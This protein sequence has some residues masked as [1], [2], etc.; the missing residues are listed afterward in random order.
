[1][2]WRFFITAYTDKG[3]TFI[4]KPLSIKVEI[5]EPYIVSNNGEQENPK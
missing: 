2:F 3:R 5:V 4:S 1:M